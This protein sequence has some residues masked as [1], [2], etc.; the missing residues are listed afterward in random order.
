MAAKN[1]ARL[2]LF[3]PAEGLTIR[4][5]PGEGP[6]H[7]AGAPSA[8]FDQIRERFYL[9]YRLRNPTERGWECRIAESRNGVHFDDIWAAR[10]EE[11][12]ASPSIERAALIKT[13][14]GRYRLYI[15]YVDGENS[16]WRIDLLEAQSPEELDPKAR[17]KVLAAEDIDSEGV[18]DPWVMMMGRL[19]YLFAGYG[20]RATI[21]PGSTEE[22]LHGTGNVFVTGRIKHPTGLAVSGDGLRF[23]WLGDVIL[24]GEGWDRSIAR[25]SC[26]VYV[27]PLFYLFYDGRTG[28]G[29]FY[30]DRTG[31]AISLDLVHIHKVTEAGPLLS[32]PWGTGALRY[33]DILPLEDTIYY[34]YECAR[35]DGS[36]ELR[37]SQVPNR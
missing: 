33:L 31:L 13:P 9:Y 17:R 3:D 35:P 11:D 37:V 25:M 5:P 21:A 2:P 6:G 32:S 36:H 8:F 1:L 10:A 30:E 14:E 22:E 7:W 18:K 12:F 19:T 29:D 28:E 4:E 16:R 24:P 27:P 26:L 15:S 23:R 20:P 34:Y